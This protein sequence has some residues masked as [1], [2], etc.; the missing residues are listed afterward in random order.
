MPVDTLRQELLEVQRTLGWMDLVLGSINDAVCVVDSSCKLVFVNDAFA[1]LTGNPRILLL[2]QTLTEVIDT[3]SLVEKLKADVNILSRAESLNGLYSSQ[4][5]AGGSVYKITAR[6][7]PTMGQAVFLMQDVTREQELDRMKNEFISLASHQLRTPLSA[8]NIYSQMLHDGYAGALK[9]E[10]KEYT[11]NIVK[12]GQRM[13]ELVNNL[14]DAAR[15]QNRQQALD[16]Q[17]VSLQTILGDVIRN[18]EP[19][20]KEKRVRIRCHGLAKS[21]NIVSDSM[22]LQ[23]VF[24]NL[25]VNAIQYSF[26]GGKIT[27]AIKKTGKELVTSVSDTGIGIPA[28]SQSDLF[29]PFYRAQNALE[30]FQSGTGLGLYFVRLIVKELNGRIWFESQE[31]K[32][33][34]FYVALPVK[35][36]KS[37]SRPSA[38]V[39]GRTPPKVVF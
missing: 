25:I 7:I 5:D 30:H 15:L 23:E 2:G 36:R 8:I 33:T 9:E 27:V 6:T 29:A 11:A 4:T 31:G 20:I 12:A 24:S 37:S 17:E 19:Q 14:L 34:T 21:P 1:K 3:A 16:L 26:K 35:R 22:R 10:Q 28:S 39:A 18:I 38:P 13:Q 32:G